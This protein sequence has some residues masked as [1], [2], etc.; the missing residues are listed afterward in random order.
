MEM[1]HR[2]RRKPM[3]EINVVPMIDVML[4]LLVVFMITAPLMSQGIRVDLPDADAEPV[5][6]TEEETLVVTI[7]S[8]G[9]YYIN[10]GD[11]TPEDPEPV[12]LENIFESV[13]RIM[14]QNPEVP[15]YLEADGAIDYGTV[16]RLMSTLVRAGAPAVQLITEP[17]GAEAP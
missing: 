12:P 9:N 8:S 5:E 7:D 10:L 2:K 14:D 4:V 15:V 6:E 13:S 3:G 1:H 17:P 11:V 16:T